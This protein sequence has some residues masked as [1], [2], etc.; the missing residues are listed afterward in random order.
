MGIECR[1]SLG[2]V[3]YTDAFRRRIRIGIIGGKGGWE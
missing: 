1:D 3:G 2:S